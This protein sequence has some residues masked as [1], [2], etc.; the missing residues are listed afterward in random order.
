MI[1]VKARRGGVLGAKD[2]LLCS[3]CSEAHFSI[4]VVPHSGSSYFYLFQ[5]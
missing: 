1:I 3:D 2:M 5:A 4:K